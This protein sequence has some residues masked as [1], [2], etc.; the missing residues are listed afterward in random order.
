MRAAFR[1]GAAM[2]N[3]VNALREPG[4]MEAAAEL[5]CRFA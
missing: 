2:I 1:A 5:G 4:A 3:D